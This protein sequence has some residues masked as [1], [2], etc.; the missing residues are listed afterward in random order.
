MKDFLYVLD[1][2]QNVTLSADWDENEE[3]WLVQVNWSAPLRA[4]AHYNV[5]LRTNLLRR[6]VKVPGVGIIKII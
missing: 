1:T 2:A 3:S 4:P 6:S 5:T